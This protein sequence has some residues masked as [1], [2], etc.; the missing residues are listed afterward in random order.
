MGSDF[1]TPVA[2]SLPATGYHQGVYWRLFNDFLDS[3]VPL[4]E[5]D[6]RAFRPNLSVKQVHGSLCSML[7]DPAS[8]CYGLPVKVSKREEHI[9]LVRAEVSE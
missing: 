6:W 4:A 1:L 3:A 9:Y 5:L 2:G 7:S 8:S